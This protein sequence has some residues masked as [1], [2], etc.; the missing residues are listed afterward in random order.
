M[1]KKKT[2]N[3]ENALEINKVVHGYFG[4]PHGF[5]E[6]LYRL[7]NNRYVI[8]RR[9]GQ[10]SPYPEENIQPILKAELK[11]LDWVGSL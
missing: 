7:R 2:I 8:V 3:L 9:G 5:E 6:I 4:D 10:Y 1:E 11:K